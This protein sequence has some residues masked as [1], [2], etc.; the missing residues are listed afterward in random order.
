ML[1]ENLTKEQAVWLVETFA[2]RKNGIV[3]GKTMGE[4]FLPAREYI[5][6]KAVEAPGCGCHY[7]SYAK[8][9]ASMYDQHAEQI[10][11]IAYEQG[12]TEGSEQR[13]QTKK[14]IRSKR[15]RPKKMS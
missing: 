7:L 13:N 12:T 4:Y 1:N 11:V 3:N 5:T 2:M 10:K 14:K 6:G 9:T 8:M 15:G